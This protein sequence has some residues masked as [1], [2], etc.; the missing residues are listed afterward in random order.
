MPWT[1]C[2]RVRGYVS[3]LGVLGVCQQWFA[4]S[5]QSVEIAVVRSFVQICAACRFILN[6][7]RLEYAF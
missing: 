4:S 1:P 2:C 3:F 6:T 7:E 5:K